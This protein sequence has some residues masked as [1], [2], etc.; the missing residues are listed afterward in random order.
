MLVKRMCNGSGRY[1]YAS[2][3]FKRKAKDIRAKKD[4]GE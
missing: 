4:A 3:H 1:F 2:G